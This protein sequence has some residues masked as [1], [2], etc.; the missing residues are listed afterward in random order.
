MYRGRFRGT[1]VAV[2]TAHAKNEGV[3]SFLDEFTRELDM[4]RR[5]HH[6]NIITFIGASFITGK[7]GIVTE[8][9]K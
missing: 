1:E 8:F 6:P 2:K 9:C 5:L 3:K 4:M 7:M